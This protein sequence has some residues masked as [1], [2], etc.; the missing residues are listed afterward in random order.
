LTGGKSQFL[1]K[2][3]SGKGAY[4]QWRNPVASFALLTVFVTQSIAAERFAC[5]EYFAATSA[6]QKKAEPGVKGTLV[7]DAVSKKVEFLNPKGTE[8]FTIDYDSIR[9]MQYERTEQP[10]YVAAVFVSPAFLLTRSKK[11]YLTIEYRD[12]AGEARSV[13]V[14]LNKR[15]ARQ[16]VEAITAQTNK[17]VEQIKEK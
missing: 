3:L 16:A 17:S 9:A 5:A 6:G 10:R 8:A 7:F 1:Q 2:Y 4:M 14:R 15:N 12:Q 11:H 13:I